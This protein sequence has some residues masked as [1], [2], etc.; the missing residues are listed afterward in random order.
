[1]RIQNNIAALNAHR[2]YGVNN[3]KI[4][5]SV[6]KLSSGY[7]I[8]R[9]GDDAAG[10]AISEKMR[11]QIRGLSMA[12]KNAQDGVSLIQTAE[13]GL[14]SAH[15]ILQRMRELA[16]QAGND[17]NQALDRDAIQDEIEQL[18]QELDRVA[19]TTSFN[20]R[21]LLDGSMAASPAKGANGPRLDPAGLAIGGAI[22]KFTIDADAWTPSGNTTVPTANADS[23]VE[24]LGAVADGNGGVEVEYTITNGADTD[25]TGT[26]KFTITADDIANNN[27]AIALSDTITADMEFSDDATVDSVIKELNRIKVVGAVKD[28]PGGTGQDSVFTMLPNRLVTNAEFVAGSKPTVGGATHNGTWTLTATSSDD[29]SNVQFT[30]KNGS[31]SQHYTAAL[32]DLSGADDGDT[33]ALDFGDLGTIQLTLSNNDAA[34]NDIDVTLGAAELNDLNLSFE[35]IGGSNATEATNPLTLQVGANDGKDQTIQVSVEG[36][37]AQSLGLSDDMT[38]TYNSGVQG[39]SNLSMASNDD[40]QTAI[41]AIDSALDSVSKQRAALGAVQNRLEYTIGN[42]DIAAENITAA[43][44]RIRDVDMAKEMTT[45][46]KNNILGQA[47]TAMLAQANSLPQSVLQ[48]LG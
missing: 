37:S 15:D 30:L 31:V 1:M 26:Y 9:A 10:L 42:L 4:A 16:V 6:E 24:L 2:N 7:R 19:H 20:K 23:T 46:M 14:Q 27:S 17:T 21:I 38:T 8:N 47:A 41:K 5:K 22:T 29:M 12:S 43:E 36:I 35:L 25:I 34:G 11:A 33:F 44:S 13:G 32:N 18:T 45:F 28:A 39:K 48:L 3:A 40:A